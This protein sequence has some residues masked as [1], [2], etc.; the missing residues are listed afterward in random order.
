MPELT[1]KTEYTKTAD[2]ERRESQI[3]KEDE[4]LNGWKLAPPERLSK[5]ERTKE[6]RDKD[7]QREEEDLQKWA[8]TAARTLLIAELKDAEGDESPGEKE[9]KQEKIEKEERKKAKKARTR[10]L[11]PP[12]WDALPL[13]QNGG[14]A[15]SS[16][17]R[18][19]S[20]EHWIDSW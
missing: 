10:P 14:Q 19:C 7:R 16:D 4:F 5:P 13:T 9:Y 18:D 11:P 17:G 8:K 3:K 20:V 6:E 1:K 15:S 2:E 12:C